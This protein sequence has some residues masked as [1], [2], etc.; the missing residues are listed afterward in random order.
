MVCAF[1]LLTGEIFAG[2]AFDEAVEAVFHYHQGGVDVGHDQ[3][4]TA[5]GGDDD[6]TRR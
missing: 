6:G 1:C 5:G 3:L 4:N 2:D